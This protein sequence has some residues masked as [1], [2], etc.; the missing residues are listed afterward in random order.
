MLETKVYTLTENVQAKRDHL[1]N[2]DSEIKE[3]QELSTINRQKIEDIES[4][5][6]ILELNKDKERNRSSESSALP[7]E[8]ITCK[9]CE[10]KFSDL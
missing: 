4:K 1:T 7:S 10:I 2:L 6:Q 9:Q 5:L 3:L 8:N